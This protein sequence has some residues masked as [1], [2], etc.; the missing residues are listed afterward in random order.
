MLKQYIFMGKNLKDFLH[1]NWEVGPA[2]GVV[3]K[4]LDITWPAAQFKFWT[5]QFEKLA[6]CMCG[7]VQNFKRRM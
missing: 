3:V 2:C 4:A 6:V 5:Q 7:G 1:R